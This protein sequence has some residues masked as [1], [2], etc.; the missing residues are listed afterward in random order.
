MGRKK[1]KVEIGEIYGCYE[2][3]SLPVTEGTHSF[4]DVKCVVCNNIYHLATSEIVGR[5][6]QHCKRC[7]AIIKYN[8][9]EIGTIFKYLMVTNNAITYINGFRTV[10]CECIYCHTKQHVR[11]ISL[12]NLHS[13]IIKC[14]GCKR[15]SDLIKAEKAKAITARKQKQPF[16]TKLHRISAQAEHRSIHVYITPNDLE[17]LWNKQHGKCAIT[18]DSLESV[19]KASLDR[20]DSSKPYEM[21]NIQW[22]TKQANLSKHKMTMNELI[23]FCEKVLKH[24]N[25]Q[26]SQPLTK[27]E[28]SETKD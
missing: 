26:P 6:K 17:N 1:V 22:V 25:Q 23:A 13:K 11:I 2:I 20:I 24:V 14:K 7:R 16:L 5:P 12:Y 4:V 8:V 18:G 28:G 9:P 27:L 21:G 3:L 10:E 15:K 19:Y